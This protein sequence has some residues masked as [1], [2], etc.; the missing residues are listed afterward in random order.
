MSEKTKKAAADKAAAI[1][2]KEVEPVV[3]KA[4]E[5]KNP[6]YKTEKGSYELLGK[7]FIF[8]QVKYTAKEAVKNKELMEALIAANSPAI[9]KN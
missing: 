4:T 9:K 2:A 5:S 7:S 6:V 8:K 3:E 1:S